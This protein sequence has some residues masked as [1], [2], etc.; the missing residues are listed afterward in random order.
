MNKNTLIIPLL[1]TILFGCDK[2]NKTQKA[3]VVSSFDCYQA[4]NDKLLKIDFSKIDDEQSYQKNKPGIVQ[5]PFYIPDVN[6]KMITRDRVFETLG[7]N[8]DSKCRTLFDSL[9]DFAGIRYVNKDFIS[10]EICRIERYT[11]ET[12]LTNRRPIET[13]RLVFNQSDKPFKTEDFLAPSE[14]LIHE[15]KL[16]D[17]WT[18]YVSDFE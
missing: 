3:Q 11:L 4:M 2:I 8:K 12:R 5:L 14:K 18:Y 6:Y 17:K 13:H 7:M 9:G 1:L 15:E 16:A 10:Y